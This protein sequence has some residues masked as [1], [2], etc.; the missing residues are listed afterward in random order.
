MSIDFH[1]EQPK[2]KT[3]ESILQIIQPKGERN[4]TIGFDAHSSAE[5]EAYDEAVRGILQREMFI[6]HLDATESTDT[7]HEWIIGDNSMK[8]YDPE[9]VT[10]HL[11]QVTEEIDRLAHHYLSLK[12]AA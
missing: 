9:E 10:E 2:E 12:K 4:W 6:P 1:E 3:H 7:H 11:S 8:D 5:I